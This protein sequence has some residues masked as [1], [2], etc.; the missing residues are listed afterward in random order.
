MGILPGTDG[1]VKMSKSLGNHIALLLEP[2]DM[3]GKV[4]SVPDKAMGDYY[5]F[6]S[7][8]TPAEIDAI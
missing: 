2:A 4:M 6:L 7:R 8:F 5:R 3:Y 1:E